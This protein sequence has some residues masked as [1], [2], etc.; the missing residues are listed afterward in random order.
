MSKMSEHLFTLALIILVIVGWRYASAPAPSLIP[1]QIKLDSLTQ[2]LSA[3]RSIATDVQIAAKK[4]SFAER[5]T[6]SRLSNK[7]G[8]LRDSLVR[9]RELL[10]ADTADR[11]Q[12]AATLEM[13][14][15]EAESTVA[16]TLA[17]I[18]TVDVLRKRYAEERRAMSVAL[19]RADSVIAQQD[20][21]IRTLRTPECQILGRRCPSRTEV[22]L[23][24]A[25]VGI[26]ASLLTIR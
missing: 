18:D 3:T 12:L 9:A 17:Y 20:R 8:I 14:T 25:S 22:L 10:R 7:L 2:A 23:V 26:L 19:E 11:A 4:A 5:T 13:V 21:M 24:G 1:Q 6:A 15:K 16:I